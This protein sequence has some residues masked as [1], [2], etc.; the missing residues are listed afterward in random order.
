ME[1]IEIVERKDIPTLEATASATM[2]AIPGL[3]K[4]TFM[5]ATAILERRQVRMVE[6]PFIRYFDL[7]WEAFAKMG[8]LNS[9]FS[10]FFR[11]WP[12]RLGVMVPEAMAAQDGLSAGAFPGGRYLQTRHRG[13]YAKV[14]ETYKRLQAYAAEND[15]K[16]KGE[17]AE[18]YVSDPHAVKPEDLETVVLIPLA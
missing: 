6:A 5:T 1:S 16:L 13:P 8:K 7:D 14:A 9:L 18:I 12:M 15:L 2:F 11:R 3:C 4:K 10:C 17:S